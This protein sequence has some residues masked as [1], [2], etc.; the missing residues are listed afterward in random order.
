MTQVDITTAIAVTNLLSNY[1]ELLQV[2]RFG[3]LLRW[4]ESCE[5]L[6]P[7]QAVPFIE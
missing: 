4:A 7:L 5:R 2:A 3:A 1:P 6:L